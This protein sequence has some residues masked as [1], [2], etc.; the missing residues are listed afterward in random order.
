QDHR[1]PL[2]VMLRRLLSRENRFH[3]PLQQECRQRGLALHRELFFCSKSASAR[4]ELD[5]HF[6]LRK[7]QDISDLL[8]V[9]RGTLALRKNLYSV[10]LWQCQTGLRFEERRLNRLC[11]ERLL[12]D[13]RGRSESCLHIAT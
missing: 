2:H 12:D 1:M 5:L 3:R 6:F 13:M 4:R 10:C 11:G 8:L 9:K 7:F